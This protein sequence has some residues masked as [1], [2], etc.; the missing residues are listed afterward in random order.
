MWTAARP[1]CARRTRQAL[2]KYG[3]A[4][5]TREGGRLATSQLSGHPETS[6]PLLPAIKSAPLSVSGWAPHLLLQ[7]CTSS[8]HL[9]PQEA[10]G[11][12]RHWSPLTPLD[13][14]LAALETTG[15][16]RIEGGR[17]A[18]LLIRM[19]SS[20]LSRVEEEEEEEE[21]R[22]GWGGSAV[23]AMHV[24]AHTKQFSELAQMNFCHMACML[25]HMRFS[26][27]LGSL[28]RRSVPVLHFLQCRICTLPRSY[29]SLG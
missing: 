4:A 28:L 7:R 5:E 17:R 15:G 2:I 9:R 24:T 19:L 1:L 16:C 6:V 12:G 25:P 13:L 18:S 29:T 3:T 11:Q 10:G 26:G 21:K 23:H 22:I 8:L 14:D 27:A 20:G